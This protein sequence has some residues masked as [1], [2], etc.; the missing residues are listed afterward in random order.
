MSQ[1]GVASRTKIAVILCAVVILM[2]AYVTLQYGLD[3]WFLAMVTVA[4]VFAGL[5]VGG[6]RGD[7]ATVEQVISVSQQAMQGQFSTAAAAP[8]TVTEFYQLIKQLDLFF[9]AL[10]GVLAGSDK[11][12]IKTPA[13]N[14][15]FSRYLAQV[16]AVMQQVT[17]GQADNEKHIMAQQLN[18]L[19]GSHLV[20]NLKQNQADLIAVNEHMTSAQAI[21]GQASDQASTCNSEVGAVV[22]RLQ[23]MA[24]IIHRNDQSIGLLNASTGEITKV[25]KVITDIAE[26]TNLL[27]LNAAIEAARA[28]ESGRGFAV[29]ADEVRT[30]AEHTKKATLEIAPVIEGFK[31]EAEKMLKDA[32]ALQ[33]IATES[34]D[35]IGEFGEQMSSL[36]TAS[37]EASRLM[38]HATDMSFAALV[39]LDHILYKQNAYRSLD[40]GPDSAEAQA[41]SVDH[42]NCRLGKWYET[43][44]GAERFSNMPSYPHL[45]EPHSRVHDGAHRAQELVRVGELDDDMATELMQCFESM[46]VASTE[47]IDLI[48]Q[49]TVE[50]QTRA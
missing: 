37:H 14:S 31:K 1:L 40:K 36:S 30:L 24:D 43:G 12:P 32:S 33:G 3:G 48:G 11:E 23:K 9:T 45:I 41:I 18:A 38:S 44:E 20:Q 22:E 2:G 6:G 13:L 42:H 19:N 17:G 10:S 49:L 46:E 21:S 27:A 15:E 50:R 26:Q 25:I 29:V 7:K 4:L 8:D 34:S 5:L 47:V 35:S 39:K 16:V 28:G